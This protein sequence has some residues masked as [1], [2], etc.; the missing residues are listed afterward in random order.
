MG[1]KGEE[2]SVLYSSGGEG[3]R[4]PG[5]MPCLGEEEKKEKPRTAGLYSTGYHLF[6]Q[7]PYR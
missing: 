4:G 5:R 3:H 1:V 6:L 2:A 7:S